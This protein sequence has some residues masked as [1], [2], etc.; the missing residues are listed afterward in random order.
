VNAVLGITKTAGVR[1]RRFSTASFAKQ[2]LPLIPDELQRAL[3]PILTTIAHLSSQVD[4]YDKEFEGLCRHQYPETSQLRQVKGVGPITALHFVLTIGDASRFRK[5]R[6]IGPYLG[7]TP[8]RDQSG[9]T[10]RALGISKAGNRQ[11]RLLLVQCSHFLLGRFGEERNLRRWGLKMA[12]SG[13]KNAK[14]RAIVAVA[15]KLAI[16][17]HHLWRTG[18]VY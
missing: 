14:K 9:E 15:R 5:S 7:L 13:G 1:M 2:A 8:K 4:D 3:V 10:D 18:D 11:L 6:D 16:L 17:L 12:E